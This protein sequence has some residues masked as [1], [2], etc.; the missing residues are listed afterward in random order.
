VGACDCGGNV[1]LCVSSRCAGCCAGDICVSTA[2]QS[3]TSCGLHQVCKA[4]GA[5]TS[6]VEGVCSAGGAGGGAA[7]GGG[8]VGGGTASDGGGT[9]AS[10][11]GA[12]GGASST[13]GGAGSTGGGAGGTG[14]GSAGTGGGALGPYSFDGGWQIPYAPPQ[15]ALVGDGGTT[16]D[17]GPG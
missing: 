16:V 10:G 8:A 17:I 11:G 5:G 15:P 4:C 7:G 14:G 13:G 3:D 9:A 12:G 6:C 1:P 2:S